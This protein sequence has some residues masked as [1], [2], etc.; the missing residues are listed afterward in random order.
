MQE[1]KKRKKEGAKFQGDN[2]K[3]IASI[4]YCYPIILYTHKEGS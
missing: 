4:F 2:L 3:N 1:N